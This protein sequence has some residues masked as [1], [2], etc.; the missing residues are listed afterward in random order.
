MAWVW[1]KETVRSRGF[2]G[3]SSTRVT[4]TSL[5]LDCD[6]EGCGSC[7][8]F[9]L[10]AAVVGFD[11]ALKMRDMLISR[12]PMRFFVGAAVVCSRSWASDIDNDLDRSR[13]KARASGWKPFACEG[14]REMPLDAG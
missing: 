14:A 5:A 9:P 13:A 4:P 1:L 12:V 10:V 2:A 3:V 8:G 11:L 7:S 6:W